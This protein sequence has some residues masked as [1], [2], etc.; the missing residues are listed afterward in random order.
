MQPHKEICMMFSFQVSPSFQRAVSLC[1]ITSLL[2][3]CAFAPWEKSAV[4]GKTP[5]ERTSSAQKQASE[6]PEAAIPRKDLLVTQDQAITEL[7]TEAEKARN[8]TKLAEAI[9]LYERVIAIAPNNVRAISGKASIEREQKQ[10]VRIEEARKLN[11]SKNS[12]AALAILRGVLMETPENAEALLLQTEIRSQKPLA[13]SEPPKLKPPFQKPVTL[14]FRDVSVKMMFEALSRATGINFI[15]D[16]EI[17]SEEKATAFVKNLP[18]EEAIEMVLATNGLQK[19]ALTETSALIFPNT[20]PKNKDYKELMI[21]SFYL[22]NANAKQVSETLKIVLKAQN[23]VVDERLNMIVMRD[24][25]EVIRIAEKLVAAND[26]ADPEVMLEIEVLEVSRSRLQELG[27]NYP[28]RI[29]VL[30]SALT[31]QALKDLNDSSFGVSPNP[32]MNFRKTTG[33][34][35]L[36][37]NPRIRVRNNE[38][39]KVL[40]G[41]K[42]PIITTTSTA[43]VGIAE[44]VSYLDVGLK[45]DVQPRITLDDFV[46]IKIEL[47]VS[48]LG[49]PTITKSGATVYTIGNRSASTQLRLKDGETQVLAG[50]ISDDERKSASKL[51]AFSDIP[52]L[53]RLF[54]NQEDKKTKTEI[55]LAITPRILGNISRPNA[56]ISEYW[57]GTELQINDKPQISIP[58][59]KSEYAGTVRSEDFG[60]AAGQDLQSPP[61][62]LP[63][64]P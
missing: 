64:R 27:I 43:L 22:A 19:K 37:S 24:T 53:G 5:E 45:L 32:G 40:V 47:E 38:K 18:I 14:E 30:S 52:L 58:A 2:S 59:S 12:D 13:R 16:K 39:A 21:R 11:A 23:L 42:V 6:K 25:P 60:N 49:A 34:I 54:A 61:D 3:S 26:L 36:I 17:R 35:N 20:A 28:N 9:A 46:N 48:S 10:Q 51:P 31:I 50:L 56:E 62:D 57:S 4:K 8:N 63:N 7:L 55:V 29:S 1:L 44:S 15:L 33:D 41:D